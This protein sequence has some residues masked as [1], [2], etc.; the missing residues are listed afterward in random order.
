MRRSRK[1][2][3]A[4]PSIEGSNPSLSASAAGKSAA[5]RLLG[6]R[7][8]GGFNLNT[9]GE[10]ALNVTPALDR[11][12]DCPH[13]VALGEHELLDLARLEFGDQR[14]EVAHR[15]ADGAQLVGTNPDGGRFGGHAATEGRR[16]LGRNASDC[17]HIGDIPSDPAVTVRETMASA[18]REHEPV[19]E[20]F[21]PFSYL[22]A[23]NAALYRQVML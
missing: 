14:A 5:E 3:W 11:D 16:R 8:Y 12:D 22:T 20:R 6:S 18:V 9:V 1:P 4:V 2:V 19:P 15:L 21:E 7:R 10:S 13:A 17:R 23:P